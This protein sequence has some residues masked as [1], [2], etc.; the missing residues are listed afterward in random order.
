MNLADWLHCPRCKSRLAAV[1]PT[2]PSLPSEPALAQVL[3]CSNCAWVIP[4]VDGVADFVGD[5]IISACDPF[6]LSGSQSD[7]DAASAD[8]MARIRAAAEGRWPVSLGEVLE[9]GCGSGQLTRMLALHAEVRGL[10]VTD[11]AMDMVHHCRDRLAGSVPGT[12]TTVI[13][14]QLS[15]QEDSVRDAVAD[16]VAGTHVLHRFGDVRA[17][18]TM[19]HRVLKPAGRA[20]FVVPN[21]RYYQAFCQATATA[22][23]QMNAR[24][25]VWSEPCHA[26]MGM[27]AQLR[28]QLLHQG[29]Q[30]FLSSLREKH[31]FDS[32]ALEDLAREVGFATIDAVP[33]RPDPLG[34]DATRRFC[35]DAG[36]PDTFANEL[37]PLVASAGAPFYSLLSRQDASASLLLWL[38]KGVGPT[39]RTFSVQPEPPPIGFT[40]PNSALGGAP[41]RWSVELAARNSPDGVVVS[42]GGWCLVNTD[43]VWLRLSLDGVSRDAPVWRPRPDVHGALNPHGRYHPLNALCCGM[44][45]DLLFDGVH[46]RDKQCSLSVE[47]VLANGLIARGPAPLALMMDEPLVIAQ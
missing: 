19:V 4:T 22:L 6:A 44:E 45:I 28:R 29:D 26:V 3:Q 24:D 42:V 12:N 43:V 31:L 10:M 14:V 16:T 23:V 38:T 7:D 33:L 47:I 1:A 46:P 15:G 25:G 20:F 21:R 17:F 11:T 18:L 35:H 34:G 37:A 27:L 5:R 36:I 13:Y 32:D 41:P 39:L 8:L 30:T 9:L 2:V 40:A